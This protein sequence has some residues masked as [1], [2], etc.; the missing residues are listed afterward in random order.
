MAQGWHSVESTRLPPMWPEFKSETWRQMWV[1]FVIGS[2][3]CSKRFFSGYSGFTLSSKTKISKLQFDLDTVD[4]EQPCGCA[5]PNSHLFFIFIFHLLDVKML[6]I[7]KIRFE[8]RYLV[9][10]EHLK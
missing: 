8:Y 7:C 5:T 4:E 6:K 3:P 9:S 2:R 1:E 10:G